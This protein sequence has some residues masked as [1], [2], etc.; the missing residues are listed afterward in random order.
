MAYA[1]PPYPGTARRFYRSESNYRGEVDHAALIASLTTSYDGWAL[2]TSARALADILPLC[3]D[4]A[5]VCAWIKPHCAA[6]DSYGIHNCW[7]PLI[8]VPGRRRRPGKRDWLSALPARGGGSLPGRK[9]LA[10]CAWLFELLGLARG[11]T[12]VDLF[13]GTNIV[14]RSWALLSSG[15]P[16]DGAPSSPGVSDG[17]AHAGRRQRADLLASH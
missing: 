6:R 2:S 3:P 13:P 8:V 11:D 4:S 17:V 14:S 12:F 15:E 1:D 9:P 16:N 5:R 7:E 10:F